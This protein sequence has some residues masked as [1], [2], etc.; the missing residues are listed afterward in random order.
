MKKIWFSD[1][2]WG[3]R[4]VLHGESWTMW[5]KYSSINWSS[6]DNSFPFQISLHSNSSRS[7]VRILAIHAQQIEKNFLFHYCWHKLTTLII[8]RNFFCFPKLI[9][10]R[11]YSSS[12]ISFVTAKVFHKF[13]VVTCSV[14]KYKTF[15]SI[16]NY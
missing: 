2:V 1:T 13:F 10:K 12:H 16:N 15:I 6:S 11:K 9:L 8:V 3:E 7:R 14:Q 4:G 5:W